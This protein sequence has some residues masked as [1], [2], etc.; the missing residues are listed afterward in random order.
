MQNS[1]IK[2][3]IEPYGTI[4]YDDELRSLEVGIAYIPD[5]LSEDVAEMRDATNVKVE[6]TDKYADIASQHAFLV[7]VDTVIFKTAVRTVFPG[8]YWSKI[9]GPDSKQGDLGHALGI[10]SLL[11]ST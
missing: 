6:F 10:A 7:T 1:T 3:G 5:L 4:T 9:I 11:P 8:G 2:E